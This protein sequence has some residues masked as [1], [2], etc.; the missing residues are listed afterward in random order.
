MGR[1]YLVSLQ[2]AECCGGALPAL[3]ILQA[4]V[5]TTA[6]VRLIQS[7]CV[8]QTHHS[9]SEDLQRFTKLPSLLKPECNYKMHVEEF[10]HINCGTNKVML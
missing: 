4:A 10:F 5:Q 2:T 6:V 7:V 8:L 1:T 9:S 3:V